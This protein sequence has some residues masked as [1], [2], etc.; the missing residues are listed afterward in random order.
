M[1]PFFFFSLLLVLGACT[2]DQF[3]DKTTEN[4]SPKPTTGF[5][6]TSTY[7]LSEV[8]DAFERVGTI[9][10][11]ILDDF[12]A[13]HTTLPTNLAFDVNNFCIFFVEQNN[14]IYE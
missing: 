8:R 9:H 14:F 2:K 11:R 10:N 3:T 13:A 4:L 12:Y 6:S 5:R 1:K 7:A